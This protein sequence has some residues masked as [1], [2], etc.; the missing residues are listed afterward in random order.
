M[1][2]MPF[3]ADGLWDTVDRYRHLWGRS[4]GESNT[5]I[6]GGKIFLLRTIMNC[7]LM[8]ATDECELFL[9]AYAS[10]IFIVTGSEAGGNRER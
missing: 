3:W 1:S 5:A 2:H 9:L 7:G 8:R 10:I 6:A 4:C